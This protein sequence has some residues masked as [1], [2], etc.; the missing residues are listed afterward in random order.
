MQ[1][2]ADRINI[3]RI[4]IRHNNNSVLLFIAGKT[5]CTKGTAASLA[6]EVAS[7][8]IDPVI[9]AIRAD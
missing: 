1:T 4:S 3:T 5:F 6:M 8:P 9:A 7:H 2:H